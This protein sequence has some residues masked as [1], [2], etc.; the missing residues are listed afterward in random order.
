MS[1]RFIELFADAD[2]HVTTANTNGEQV[3]HFVVARLLGDACNCDLD[4][5]SLLHGTR[6]VDN[7]LLVEHVA[8]NCTSREFYKA[9]LEDRSKSVFTGR[10][11]VVEGAQKTDA[12]QTSQAMIQSDEAEAISKPQLEIY[13]DDV[14]CTHGATIGQIDELALYYLQSR[15]IDTATA[16]EMLIY[17]FANEIIGGVKCLHTRRIIEASLL[18]RLKS[19]SALQDTI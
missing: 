16:R 10:I 5:I 1:S 18:A 4:G 11:H 12:V 19:G 15:G 7:N 8:P 14:K 17:A 6:H 3:R 2:C 9:I 13:A